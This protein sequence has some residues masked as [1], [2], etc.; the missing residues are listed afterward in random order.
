M[1][2]VCF[3]YMKYL[4]NDVLVYGVRYWS[5]VGV[6]VFLVMMIV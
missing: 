2:V 3:V 1:R 6:F 5:V 4:V